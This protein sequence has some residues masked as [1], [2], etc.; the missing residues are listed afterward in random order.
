MRGARF[1]L[2]YLADGIDALRTRCRLPADARAR[3]AAQDIRRILEIVSTALDAG[4][5]PACATLPT[6]A[7]P[8][9]AASGAASEP[10][11]PRA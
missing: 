5:C 9:V 7:T 4:G 11:R 8:D 10:G 6:D 1:Q 2:G 3:E